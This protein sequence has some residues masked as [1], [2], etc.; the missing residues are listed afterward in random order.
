MGVDREA[1]SVRSRGGQPERTE[2]PTR[3][4]I[5][6]FRV[7]GVS[8]RIANQVGIV[9]TTTRLS[10]RL[11]KEGVLDACLVQAARREHYHR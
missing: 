6:P 7:P 8:A 5:W 11:R 3:E 2:Y 9:N 1:A 10:R 4:R